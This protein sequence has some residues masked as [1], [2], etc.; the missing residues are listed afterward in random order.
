MGAAVSVAPLIYT[1]AIAYA[2]KHEIRGLILL[3][4]KNIETRAAQRSEPGPTQA[5]IAVSYVGLCGSD[6]H[7]Y[8]GTYSG[9]NAYPLYFGHE[10]YGTVLAVGSAVEGLSVGDRVTGDCSMYCGSCEYCEHDRNLCEHIEKFG[11]TTDGATRAVFV[12]DQRF[13]YRLPDG[14]P[15]KLGCLVEPLAVGLHAARKV[16]ARLRDGA[17]K[18]VLILGGGAIGLS[19]L[20]ALKTV[21]RC[22]T[23][24]LFDILDERIERARSLGADAL[25]NE[26]VA[27]AAEADESAG[28]GA[29][30]DSA[31]Y[32]IVFETTGS[33]AALKT[34][35]AVAR[36][37]GALVAVG[38]IPNREVD[39]QLKQIT[40]KALTV[41]GS[42]GGTGEFETVIDRIHK[43]PAYFSLILTHEFAYTD[44]RAAFEM[45]LDRKN[46]VKVALRF[47]N[48][49]TE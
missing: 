6:L 27:A 7:L 38:F 19:V 15:P 47:D 40:L 5:L 18:R 41:V 34:A 3:G 26:R 17:D 10:W 48:D 33:P 13:L 2:M 37:L 4:P 21:Y 23:V 29:L 36:P 35:L 11:I 8:H 30:Y 20:T 25:D 45:A 44:H 49:S 31:N 46:V 42:I 9:P 32:D 22:R 12:Q 28:Y 24:Q 16:D 43:T 14:F 1:I 39:Y